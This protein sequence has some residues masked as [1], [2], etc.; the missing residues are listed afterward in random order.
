MK[1]RIPL[2]LVLVPLLVLTSL[3]QQPAT[4]PQEDEVVRIT[5][6]LVQ[7]DAVITDK[8]GKL[9]TDLKPEELEI[10]ENGR[11]QKIT[12][13]SFFLAETA[14]PPPPV[15]READRNGVPAPP[16]KLRPD[17]VRRTIA[18]VVDDLGLSFE[19]THYVRR[20]LKKFVDEQ[21]Q[22]G[23]LVAII[24]TAGGMGALQQFTSDK[25]QLYAAIERVKWFANGRG[26]IGVF[27][28]LQGN[29]PS[30]QDTPAAQVDN[31]G[32]HSE[33]LDEFREDLFSV[34]TLGAVNY[35]VK[36]LK[37]LPGRKS[38]LLISDG[39][40]IMSRVDPGDHSERVLSALQSLTEQANRASVVIYTMQASGLQTLGL[41]AADNTSGFS[42]QQLRDQE[43]SRRDSF[44]E[45]QNGL[46]FLADETGGI[47]IRNNNDLSGGIKRV[48]EDQSG[49]YLIGYR[50]DDSTFDSR[51][52]RKFHKLSL[53]VL[54]P[55]KF[56]VRMRK[57]FIGVPDSEALPPAK[58]PAQQ[59]IG[60]VTS[61]F[62]SAGVHLRLT[63]L[64][65]N[66]AKAG[67]ILRSLLHVDASDLTF[68]DEPDGW[69]KTV[70]D[71]MAITFG[72]NG[73]VIDQL[74]H[75]HT[76]RVRGAEYQRMLQ[77][78]F[79]YFVTVPIKKPGGYQLRA[80][81]RDEASSR[82]GSV[83]QF[84]EVPDLKKNR[85]NI[86]GILLSSV[87]ASDLKKVN[88][89]T[90]GP[91]NVGQEVAGSDPASS[92]AVRQFRRGAAISYGYFIYNAKLNKSTLRPEL[93]TQIKLFREGQ[94][95]FTGK[96][97]PFDFSNQPDLKR[98][99]GG[100]ALQLGSEMAPG[101][102]VL[103]LL[104]TDIFADPKHRTTT[105]WIDFEIV[106]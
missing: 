97:L 100:G 75:I 57:G 82:V 96:E 7:V 63:S 72:D 54:R 8:H 36:G 105:Q 11:P 83:S 16:V 45:S 79:V 64:F 6:K 86:S 53:K 81:L 44:F 92:A 13:F 87:L 42:S 24:R 37:D 19:S 65:A 5:T 49:Y 80:A 43:N 89:P 68:T 90:I 3:A 85:L 40:P 9:V 31:V 103:Q 28:P 4:K 52:R 14:P 55:G 30:G 10:S 12:N 106:Q 33:D 62:G 73:L 23:D 46:N 21:M 93:I 67:S 41:T 26:G 50:P 77:R 74:S 59:L 104:V 15:A 101:D 88:I 25:R 35:V 61:P 51:G 78:G 76:M 2:V 84:V 1:Y 27:A 29:N 71:I 98:M 91:T 20:A 95:V 69:H 47:A 60:A 18:L 102:Y 34:G 22:P 17:Q 48:M 94:L 32:L 99:T 58:T 56:N 39:I 66:D 38:I 70:F